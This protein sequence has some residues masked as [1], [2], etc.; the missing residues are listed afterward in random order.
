[1]DVKEFLKKRG[2]ILERKVGQGSYAVVY[3]AQRQSDNLDVAVK[4]ISVQNFNKKQMENA[5][6]EVR[7]ICSI[8]HPNIVKYF[9]A[10]I[11]QKNKDLYVFMEFLGGGDLSHR[12]AQMKRAN[13]NFGEK[14]VWRYTLQILQGLKALHQRQIIHR[15]IKP[16]NLF[17]SSDYKELKIGDL[18]TSKIMGDKKLT[19]TVIGT[20]YYLAPEI[21]RS[22]KYDYRCDVFSMGCVVYEMALL[23]PPF[24][25]N[26]VEDLYKL[27]KKG[28]YQALDKKYSK[29]LQRFVEQCLLNN[30]KARPSTKKLIDSE[31]VRYQFVK[32]DDLDLRKKMLVKPKI[33]LAYSKVPENMKEVK[34]ALDNF[35][36]INQGATPK[37][38][39]KK[40][41]QPVNLRDQVI[42][43]YMNQN[44]KGS[45]RPGRVPQVSYGKG[46]INKGSNGK[47][48]RRGTMGSNI[49]NRK[50]SR[51]GNTQG[52][53]SDKKKSNKNQ[54]NIKPKKN[55]KIVLYKKGTDDNQ[56]KTKKPKGSYREIA[57]KNS[58]TDQSIKSKTPN[59]PR[60]PKTQKNLNKTKNSTN[61]QERKTP[62]KSRKDLYKKVL[63]KM[64][65]SN[66]K[67][68]TAK[69]K[70][71][72]TE[73]RNKSSNLLR[74]PNSKKRVAKKSARSINQ[75][76]LTTGRKTKNSLYNKNCGKNSVLSTRAKTAKGG[77]YFQKVN[78]DNSQMSV[79]SKKNRRKISDSKSGIKNSSKG[80]KKMRMRRKT[81][82][83]P[84]G[85]HKK[86]GS[87]LKNTIK[88]TQTERQPQTPKLQRRGTLSD[89]GTEDIKRNIPNIINPQ[90][91]EIYSYKKNLKHIES[92]QNFN[93]KMLVPLSQNSGFGD[94]LSQNL[95]F[96]ENTL[97]ATGE[98]LQVEG[99]SSAY[100]TQIDSIERS[101]SRSPAIRFKSKNRIQNSEHVGISSVSM[102]DNNLKTKK[103]S[104]RRN[105]EERKK[106]LKNINFGGRSN[107]VGNSLIQ[108]DSKTNP[109][110]RIY[111]N[112]NSGK[113]IQHSQPNPFNPNYPKVSQELPSPRSPFKFLKGDGADGGLDPNHPNFHGYDQRSGVSA[114]PRRLNKQVSLN[115][116]NR[117]IPKS[118]SGVSLR[119]KIAS[120]DK[121]PGGVIIEEDQ[122]VTPSPIG[123]KKYFKGYMNKNLL[124]T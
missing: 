66:I 113:Y 10:L 6:N 92:S 27:I 39:K 18:N 40:D 21:W 117:N 44:R 123:Q 124:P 97:L 25:G 45:M 109:I 77:I 80:T 99:A 86:K 13:T 4:V 51:F 76:N 104:V 53:S 96:A 116:F 29:E 1:M 41:K 71:N 118:P 75:S 102:N 42:G 62:I 108:K 9:D 7:I 69:S 115:I 43:A 85:K 2:Y 60:T 19:N 37:K 83:K 84:K 35:R 79:K 36:N 63:K 105:R 89:Q 52:I 106:V 46:S 34:A 48:T 72:E 101:N 30:Y 103:F 24:K 119:Q 70:Q 82:G 122:T 100:V 65:T 26:S 114:P 68:S 47:K 110:I 94:S 61:A 95:H 14:Q 91:K 8:D 33:S 78:V 81:K 88:T 28:N 3:K 98:D 32:H 23:K 90:Q 111:S 17:L 56:S 57:K 64:Q 50:K 38:V 22:S 93:K 73:K 31:M 15:D 120:V 20:P 54:T 74:V 16:G 121:I 11:D 12:I 49:D 59:T 5:I 87:E 112:E 107:K 67:S 58:K 55:S